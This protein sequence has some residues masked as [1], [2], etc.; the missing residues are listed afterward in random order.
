[1]N[2][3]VNVPMLKI[4][5]VKGKVGM[6]AAPEIHYWRPFLTTMLS[7]NV[8]NDIN[9]LFYSMSIALSW[10][11]IS[12]SIEFDWIGSV[13]AFVFAQSLH[14]SGSVHSTAR[15]VKDGCAVRKCF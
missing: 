14:L 3:S 9:L 1:M 13:P 2:N 5:V 8:A 11:M 4:G 12:I 7:A 10:L 15:S 6:E